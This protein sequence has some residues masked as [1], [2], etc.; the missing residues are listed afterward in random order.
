MRTGAC[1][2]AWGALAGVG[3]LLGAAAPAPASSARKRAIPSP[4]AALLRRAD[5]GRPW[6]LQADAPKHA[7]ALTCH[8]FSPR[9]PGVTA[10][11][12]VASPTFARGLQ[13]PFVS[14]TA[15]RYA[16]PAQQQIVWRR[17]VVPRLL[18][19]VARAL[20]AGASGGARFTVTSRKVAPLHG[21]AAPVTRYRIGGSATSAGQTL[22]VY[23]DE[24][25]LGHGPLIT[26]LDVSSFAQPPADSLERRL[27]RL[28]STRL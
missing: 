13:G 7:P 2:R 1:R 3:L 28:A 17:V 4:T 24:L 21:A 14:Q 18:R 23:L 25:V 22:P 5:L 9:L 11:A 6:T 27:V 12:A 16:T 26:S 19:C 8:G 20:T 10:P 15:Y